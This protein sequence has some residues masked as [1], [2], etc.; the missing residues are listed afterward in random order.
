MAGRVDPAIG[1]AQ[2]E[3]TLFFLL[4]KKEFELVLLNQHYSAQYCILLG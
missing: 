4:Q 2:L 3:V 1:Q